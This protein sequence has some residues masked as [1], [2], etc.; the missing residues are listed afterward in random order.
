M[1]EIFIAAFILL[2]A[3]FFWWHFVY[4]N[5]N[6]LIFIA[7]GFIYLTG[8]AVSN[9]WITR[10][11]Y[12]G[13]PFL[14]CGL[15]INRK[16]LLKEG[17]GLICC[18]GLIYG[19]LIL[20]SLWGEYARTLFLIKLRIG[21]YAIGIVLAGSFVN[22]YVQYRKL[23]LTLSPVAII[24][25]TF[26]LLGNRMIGTDERLQIDLINPNGLSIY[27]GVAASILLMSISCFNLPILIKTL[28][29]PFTVAG[30]YYL[31]RTGS[32]AG[33][34]SIM[35]CTFVMLVPP[36][37]TGR[38]NIIAGISFLVIICATCVVL[39]IDLPQE[40]KIRI[41]D[42]SNTSGRDVT[43]DD[44]VNY[45]MNQMAWYGVGSNVYINSLNDVAWG[46]F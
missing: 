2:F 7:I 28:F 44:V 32:R 40:L 23:M 11:R 25:I 9:D 18:V 20:G 35:M 17:K 30:Y 41:V 4:T 10:C 31:I 36:L 37:M 29:L 1:S 14:I 27:F 43:W 12:L 24:H 38:R 46:L 3:V 34:L 6:D 39:W 33:I 19:S 16:T 8:A 42:Y 13:L 45:E 26:L 5:K 15:F 22:S 21:L